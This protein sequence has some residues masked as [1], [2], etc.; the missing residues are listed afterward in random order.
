MDRREL[1]QGVEEGADLAVA[2]DEG[3][4]AGAEAVHGDAVALDVLLEALEAAV[5]SDDLAQAISLAQV[6]E[7]QV[8]GDAHDVGGDVL[9]GAEVAAGLEDHEEDLAD[10][11]LDVGGLAGLVEVIAADLAEA[12]AV[13]LACGALLASLQ[14][15]DQ[16]LVGVPGVR[17][18]SS[19]VTVARIDH[20]VLSAF[21]WVSSCADKIPGEL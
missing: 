9:G 5:V 1:A 14:V 7:P 10:E 13:D 20:R 12:A 2:V 11:V 3:G 8:A 21:C 19:V 16:L 17:H 18:G 6:A 4:L 15:R